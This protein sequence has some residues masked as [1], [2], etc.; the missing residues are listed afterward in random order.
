MRFDFD[1]VFPTSSNSKRSASSTSFHPPASSI[2][3]PLIG[4]DVPT[5]YTFQI[6]RPNDAAWELVLLAIAEVSTLDDFVIEQVL[7]KR[8]EAAQVAPVALRNYITQ[9]LAAI[10]SFDLCINVADGWDCPYIHH[11]GQEEMLCE[12][13]GADVEKAHLIIAISEGSCKQHRLLQPVLD[14][15][16]TPIEKALYYRAYRLLG[17]F[18]YRFLIATTPTICKSIAERHYWD[19]EP[20]EQSYYH[21]RRDYYDVSD[22]AELLKAIKNEE[23]YTFED[24]SRSFGP[25]LFAPRG[26][27]KL[28]TEDI[29]SAA[30]GHANDLPTRLAKAIQQAE[31][32]VTA[33]D[34]IKPP[35][36][37][38]LD[39]EMIGSAVY[40][41]WNG[42]DD[43]V[44]INDDLNYDLMNSGYNTTQTF[45]VRVHQVST[46]EEARQFITYLQS[47]FLELSAID[48]IISAI[49]QPYTH[50]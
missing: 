28:T 23:I 3:L 31:R 6:D 19:W 34:H 37:D 40:L 41:R 13:D 46:I 22:V 9:K 38:D 15:L 7:T 27:H 35:C 42:T 30:A 43:T 18:Q 44:R 16:S 5:T 4:L 50:E 26:A 2:N 8:Q 20:G 14:G 36:L 32:Y 48:A 25:L 17:W 1:Q 10:N 12:R 47:M 33:P 21:S 39:E 49:S 29:A 11:S 45:G 24:L